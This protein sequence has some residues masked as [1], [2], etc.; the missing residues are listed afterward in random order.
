[1]PNILVFSGHPYNYVGQDGKNHS[2]FGIQYTSEGAVSPEGYPI[3]SE[4]LPIELQDQFRG[5]GLYAVEETRFP[6]KFGRAQTRIT[7]LILVLKVELQ[8]LFEQA[9]GK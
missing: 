1:M 5:P 2:G 6:G 4:N 8:N 3:F 9:A 7:K